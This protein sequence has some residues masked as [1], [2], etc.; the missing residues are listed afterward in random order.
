MNHSAEFY[1][2][3]EKVFPEYKQC[4]KW[5]KDNGEAYLSRLK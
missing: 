2:E 3:V 4:H 1:A 5:L